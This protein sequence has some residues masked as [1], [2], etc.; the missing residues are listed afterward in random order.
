MINTDDYFI[1]KE[2]IK[3]LEDKSEKIYNK[4]YKLPSDKTYKM[5]KKDLLEFIK[6]KNRIIYGGYAMNQLIINKDKTDDFY[7]NTRYDIEFYSP[8]PIK[9]SI[10]IAIYFQKK[11]MII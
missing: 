6:K 4:L 5:M 10:D 1:T 11:N 9:D 7:G 3:N 8:E 2:N